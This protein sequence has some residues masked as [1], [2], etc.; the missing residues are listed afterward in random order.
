MKKVFIVMTVVVVLMLMWSP[1]LAQKPTPT[2]PVETEPPPVET[3]P[4]KTEPVK[5]EPPPVVT[6]K[7]K[8][9]PTKVWDDPNSSKFD[10]V[11]LPG[12]GFGPAERRQV[13]LL[14]GFLLGG[15]VLAAL[16]WLLAAL[17]RS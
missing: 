9:R 6:E 2:D 10:N 4:V 11:R 13:N 5:T 14:P 16:V 12:S 15:V 17:F 8:D 7:P 1:A 3:E